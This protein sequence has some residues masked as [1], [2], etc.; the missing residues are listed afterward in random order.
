ML[1][2]AALR[3]IVTVD[4]EAEIFGDGLIPFVSVRV[5]LRRR[6]RGERDRR[7]RELVAHAGVI[8]G[9]CGGENAVAADDVR[10][11]GRTRY[12]NPKDECGDERRVTSR[13]GFLR[14]WMRMLAVSAR[15]RAGSVSR[16]SPRRCGAKILLAGRW[17]SPPRAFSIQS[18]S[19]RHAQPATLGS[20]D[21]CDPHFPVT[22][23][24][25]VSCKRKVVPFEICVV[26]K[27]FATLIG[28]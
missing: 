22:P 2:W 21:V 25:A 5:A 1:G 7:Q 27:P 23:N 3:D 13:Q 14:S 10:L 26:L 24:G 28:Y 6:C 19:S 12:Q 20:I 9:Q 16:W 18:P 8:H 15:P 4:R 17:L 11:S